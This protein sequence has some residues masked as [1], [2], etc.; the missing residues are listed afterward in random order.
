MTRYNVGAEIWTQHKKLTQH[1]AALCPDTSRNTRWYWNLCIFMFEAA[2]SV[3]I[4]ARELKEKQN[5][6]IE[7][8]S[9]IFNW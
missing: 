3:Y 2:A 8:L 9:T 4:G 5:I 7:I 6:M 1:L